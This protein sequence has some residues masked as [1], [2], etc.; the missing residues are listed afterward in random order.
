M[1]KGGIPLNK[2]EVPERRGHLLLLG[3]PEE[4]GYLILGAPV[5][6]GTHQTTLDA[7][8]Q[9]FAKMVPLFLSRPAASIEI[10]QSWVP[11]DKKDAPPNIPEDA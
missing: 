7:P 5:E 11:L 6:R 8:F 2:P 4:R 10:S 1:T 9:A 3:A